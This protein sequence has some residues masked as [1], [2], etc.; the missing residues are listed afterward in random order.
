MLC[1][2]YLL[3]CYSELKKYE[4]IFEISLLDIDSNHFVANLCPMFFYRITYV[5]CTDILFQIEKYYNKNIDVCFHASICS[6]YPYS[7]RYLY[8]YI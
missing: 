6:P 3:K 7:S 1:W 5:Q 2:S 4:E 8:F